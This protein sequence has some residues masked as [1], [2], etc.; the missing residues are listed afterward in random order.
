[1][2]EIHAVRNGL[3]SVPQVEQVFISRE[4]GGYG[5]LV[6]L[7][8]TNAEAQRA[9]FDREAEIIDAFPAT[10]FDFNLVFRCD[11]PLNEILKPKGMQL[12]AR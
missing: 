12:F 6:V 3:A 2:T 1:M 10:K 4:P 7:P 9:V 11:R 8:D 5:V